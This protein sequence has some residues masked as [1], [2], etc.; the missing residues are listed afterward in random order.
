V[1]VQ[2]PGFMRRPSARAAAEMPTS[3]YSELAARQGLARLLADASHQPPTVRR[4]RLVSLGALTLL[5]LAA[6]IAT[7]QVVSGSSGS[8]AAAKGQPPAPAQRTAPSR[9]GIA[10]SLPVRAP[11]PAARREARGDQ[12]AGLRPGATISSF[13]R[14]RRLLAVAH[15]K[16]GVVDIVDL[17]RRGRGGALEV[18]GTISAVEFAPD[19]LLW[20][21]DSRERRVLVADVQEFDVVDEVEGLGAGRASMAFT[22]DGDRALVALSG[23]TVRY[24]D[25]GERTSLARAAVSGRP[26]SVRY[27]RKRGAFRVRG[28]DGELWLFRLRTAPAAPPADAI[29]AAV[30]GDPVEPD[31]TVDFYDGRSTG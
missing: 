7:W 28:A 27:S 24:L 6:G 20:V 3:S 18:E 17:A 2:V 8:T 13:D 10:A 15:P 5:W 11:L 31:E 30:P 26:A 29:I 22:P 12:Q 1:A 16:T 21:A 25:A 14:R 23:G 4:S 19:G 9:G